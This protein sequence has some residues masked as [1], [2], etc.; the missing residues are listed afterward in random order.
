MLATVNI[1]HIVNYDLYNYGLQFTTKWAVQYWTMATI[2]FSMGWLIIVTS[3]AFQLH[4]VVNRLHRL[5]E[6]EDEAPFAHEEPVQ[7]E[8]PRI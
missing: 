2:V 3:V 5:P 6:P 1:D 4:L 8:T 7:N